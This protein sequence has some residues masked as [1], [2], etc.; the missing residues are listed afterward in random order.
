M[1]AVRGSLVLLAVRLVLSRWHW[2]RTGVQRRA[3]VVWGDGRQ[4]SATEVA[5]GVGA[6]GGDVGGGA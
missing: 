3:G 2:R 4:S 1:A 5:H 6:G